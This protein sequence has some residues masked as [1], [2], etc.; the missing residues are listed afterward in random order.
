MHDA[1]YRRLFAF[2]RMVADLLR[3]VG[4]PAWIDEL[5]P[6]TLERL[7]AEHVGD[8]GQQRQGDAVWRLR[9][10]RGW[11]YLLVLLEFQSTIDVRMALRILEYTALL[12]RELDRRDELG[13]PGRWPPVLP[14]VLYNGD[15]PWTASL[16]MRELIAP[17]PVALEPCQPSQRALLLDERRFAV[18]DLPLGNLMRSVVAF[19][20]SRVPADLVRVA[21]ALA[22]L[23]RA[24]EDSDLAQAFLDWMRQLV[25]RMRPE[26]AELEL[27]ATLEEAGMSLAD[28]VAEWPRQWREE[29]RREGLVAGR[30]AMLRRLAVVRFGEA[31]G[32]RVD[33]LLGAADGPERLEAVAELILEAD[34][35]ANLVD[36]VERLVRQP[37]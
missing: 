9:F 2:P 7:P 19:E 37:D 15:A 24:P 8:R 6:A 12:Y 30:R 16:Q 26:H 31:V 13:A 20:Q 22:E 34:S 5:D 4:H 3:A 17:V 28:R 27:G 14:V 18:D 10:R 21:R 29:G 33:A 25:N 1:T 32:E 23:L 36:R 35:G 11:L